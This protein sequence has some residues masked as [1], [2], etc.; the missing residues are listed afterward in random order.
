MTQ[1]LAYKGI[2]EQKKTSARRATTNNLD[3]IRFAIQNITGQLETNAS[4]WQGNKHKDIPKNI[5]QFIFKAIHGAHR[6]GE[7][8]SKIPTLEIRAKC[9]HCHADVE[10]LEHILLECPDNAQS[11]IWDITK[12]IWPES[13]SPWP[14]ITLGTILGCG[15]ITLTQQRTN[16]QQEQQ[17]PQDQ[18]HQ[19]PMKGASRLLRI[20]I[21]ESAHLIW[22]LRCDT[23]ING[24]RYTKDKIRSRWMSNI[25]KRLQCDR[26]TARKITRT[27]TFENLISAT[28]SKIITINNPKQK[29]W[30]TALEVLVGITP[31]RPSTN[32]V[33]R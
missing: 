18:Q 8:W 5:R 14:R 20:L 10:D 15:N 13:N 12:K 33:T 1:A 29:N 17:E 32:E 2:R 26:L 23:T 9:A 21:S 24:K 3:I 7:Y 25:N 31:P 16:D 28:W 4:I 22:A 27:A 19:E 30:V 6:I 11:T